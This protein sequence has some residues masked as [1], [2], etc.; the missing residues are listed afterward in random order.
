MGTLGPLSLGTLGPLSPGT[1]GP[2]SRCLGVISAA[3]V[4]PRETRQTV[5]RATSWAPYGGPVDREAWV[6]PAAERTG[7]EPHD[8]RTSVPDTPRGAF[9]SSTEA[10]LR[11]GATARCVSEVR[12]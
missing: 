7:T 3:P 6:S 5:R 4:G 8:D 9:V 10:Q 12:R 11:W 2:L 1:L